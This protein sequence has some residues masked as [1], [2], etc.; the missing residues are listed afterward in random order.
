MLLNRLVYTFWSS[1]CD[2]RPYTGWIISYNESTLA[3]VSVLN[4]TPNGKEGS[5]WASGAGPAADAS[6]NI[7]FLAANGT[8]DTT[9]DAQRFPSQG[10]YGN[11]FLKLSTTNNKLAVADYFNMSNTVAES[12]ADEDLGSGGALVL[13]DMVGSTGATRHLAVG[14]G[15]DQNIYLVDR[16]NMGKFDPSTN[17]IYQ[18]T[19]RFTTYMQK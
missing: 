9:L 6:G 8:F 14:A 16:D 18:E 1:H 19:L 3:Q 2:I 4:I 11:A 15:K 7:Y 12:N 13:P 10:D 5:V 17:N